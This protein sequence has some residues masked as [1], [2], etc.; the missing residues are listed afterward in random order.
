MLYYILNIVENKDRTNI[1]VDIHMYQIF[2][3]SVL[4]KT[5][6]IVGV[7]FTGLVWFFMRPIDPVDWV[8]T[9]ST[10]ISITIIVLTIGG[11]SPRAVQR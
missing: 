11:L 6:L 3:K 7:T 2:E 10:A 1:F 8:R 5:I 4:I 9:V